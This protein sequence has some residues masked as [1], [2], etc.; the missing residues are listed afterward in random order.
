MANPGYP[1]FTE[2]SHRF[3]HP[4]ISPSN[5]ILSATGKVILITGG[6]TGIGKAI[7]TA[8][9]EAQAAVVILIGR[10]EAHLKAT[11][12]ELSLVGTTKVDYFVADITDQVAVETAF[13]T[14]FHRYGKVDVLVNNAGYLSVHTSIAKSPLEDSWRGFEVNVKG[15]IITTQAFMK[16]AQPGATIINVS[17]A[18]AHIAYVE[19]F[20]GYSAAKLAGVKIMEYVQHENPELR[21]FNINP[22]FVETNMAKASGLPQTMFDDSSMFSADLYCGSLLIFYLNNRSSWCLLCLVGGPRVRFSDRQVC[23][24]ELG[25]EGIEG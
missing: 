11:Q 21:V 10:T 5:P 13:S 23:V 3:S 15:L 12:V 20:S 2:I 4:D 9:S 19:D 18:S 25:R 1:S 14:A 6:G 24:G 16:I 7:A 17:S 22:G 8:F